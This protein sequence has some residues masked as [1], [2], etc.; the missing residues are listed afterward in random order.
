MKWYRTDQTYRFQQPVGK[1]DSY[2]KGLKEIS[3][4]EQLRLANKHLKT[5]LLVW[6]KNLEIERS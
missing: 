1:R 4:L 2:G 3:E 6:G 5:K